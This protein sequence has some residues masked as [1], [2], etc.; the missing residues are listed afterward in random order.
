M[1]SQNMHNKFSER[2][3]FLF[4]SA[5]DQTDFSKEEKYLKIFIKPQNHINED[6]SS[7][8]GNQKVLVDNEKKHFSLTFQN[9]KSFIQNKKQIQ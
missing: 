9:F 3:G 1:Q 5:K 2:K 8:M 7:L 4:S 6:A